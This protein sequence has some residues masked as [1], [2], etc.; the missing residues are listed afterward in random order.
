MSLFLFRVSFYLR[1]G[2]WTDA[3]FCENNRSIVDER[4]PRVGQALED[5]GTPLAA[6]SASWFLTLYVNQLP[7]EVRVNSLPSV[8]KYINTTQI[9][10]NAD[11]MLTTYTAQCCLRVWDVLLFERTRRIL[12]QAALALID[13]NAKRMVEVSL[14]SFPYG[15][16]D[17]NVVFCSQAQ[18]LDR[19]MELATQ[20]AP[21]QFDGSE[22]LM[23]A[24][25]Q[26]TDV[27][28]GKIMDL[29]KVSFL[30]SSRG[31]LD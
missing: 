19:L 8:P 20:M 27:T 15:Q 22:L 4:F 16:L 29:Y 24:T 28:W 5:S 14:F 25:A 2:D 9:H 30:L 31:Q 11:Q 18:R 21:A 17:A 1:T 12:F 13:V 7:W 3:V 6:V 26:F 23:V 10:P